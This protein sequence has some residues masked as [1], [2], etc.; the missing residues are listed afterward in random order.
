MNET[1][2][3][4]AEALRALI[5]NMGAGKG[6]VLA[7]APE[8]IQQ[9]LAWATFKYGAALAVSLL[10]L[11]WCG[12]GVRCGIRYVPTASY[13]CGVEAR[14]IPSCIFGSLAFVAAVA[15]ALLLM[16]VLIAPK[17]YLLEYAAQ[18]AR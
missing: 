5:E 9:M 8:V 6:F 17:V 10:I 11:A 7:Q 1:D 3:A 4:L 12:W 13:D 16:K 15:N 14:I 2:K 18:L